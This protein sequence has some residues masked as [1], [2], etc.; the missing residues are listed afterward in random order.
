METH[1]SSFGAAIIF[2]IGG[3]LFVIAGLFTSSLLRPNRPNAEKLTIYESGEDTIGSAWGQFNA[4]FYVIALVFILF[5]VEIVFLFPWATVFGDAVLNNATDGLWGN[6]AIFEMFLFLAILVLGLAYVWA[7]GYL[8][9]ASD[10]GNKVATVKS[11]SAIPM[12]AYSK[13][14]D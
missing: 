2:M 8:D 13:Y 10:K 5:D 1:L 7:K 6:I 14:L 11:E 3:A 9:W 4:R 12:E